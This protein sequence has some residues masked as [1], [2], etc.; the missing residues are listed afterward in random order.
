MKPLALATITLVAFVFASGCGDSG[1][2]GD[3]T[4]GSGG[5]TSTG[6]NAGGSTS[7]TNGATTGGGDPEP[8]EMNGMTAAHNVARANVSP[9]ASTPIPP[10]SWSSD[11][12]AVA[13]A[14]AENCV[15]EHSMGDYGENLYA[16]SG[17]DATPADVVDA[18]VG[19][20]ADYDYASN[21]CAANAMCGHYTQ[22]V[23]ADSAR[24]GCGVANCSTNSPFGSGDWVL[25]VCNYDPPGNYIG[26]KPY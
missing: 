5:S 18:W 10:L 6:T 22:V 24:L 16:E 13:Q 23:W 3:S 4:D 14:Y 25:W 9:P 7:A 19:E 26:E 20:V 21:T 1:S 8:V 17:L 2:R 15:F 12:A 11:I